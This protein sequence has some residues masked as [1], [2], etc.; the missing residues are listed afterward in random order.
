MKKAMVG[1]VVAATLCLAGET[2][3][4]KIV[5]P[6]TKAE[7]TALERA[8]KAAHLDVPDFVRW[9]VLEGIE[10]EEEGQ[11]KQPAEDKA[12][13]TGEWKA[14]TGKWKQDKKSM[15]TNGGTIA[16]VGTI[17]KT[18]K[19][20]CLLTV[21]A[22]DE[23]VVPQ[24][25]AVFWS[26]S[27]KTEGPAWADRSQ[28]ILGPNAITLYSPDGKVVKRVTWNCPMGEAIPLTVLA[29]KAGAKVTVGTQT[30]EGPY[31]PRSLDQVA[32]HSH[33]ATVRFSNVSL[34]SH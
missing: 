33:G 17:G 10:V 15:G 31:P 1:V 3:D 13:A 6:L 19:L 18:V 14:M 22:W 11:A 9:E 2:R 12:T 8:A 24:A 28:V 21:E 30:L 26:W 25:V 7:L 5:V 27:G 4:E 32:L 29:T 20:Q 16:Y 23:N 34:V